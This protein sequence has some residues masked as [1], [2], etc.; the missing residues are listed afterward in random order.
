MNRQH[1]L[2][3]FAS[4]GFLLHIALL[5]VF[6][7]AKAAGIRGISW[8][9]PSCL[10][11]VV[12]LSCVLLRRRGIGWA[13]V[14]F[15]QGLFVAAVL[16]SGFIAGIFLDTSFD[17]RWYH[18]EG[19]IRLESGLDPLRETLAEDSL[20]GG[21]WS[22]R[23]VGA[24]IASAPV[25]INHYPKATEI[26]AA[27]VYASTG[28]IEVAKLF[29]ILL[30]LCV[31]ALLRAIFLL[32]APERR[33]TAAVAPIALVGNPIVVAQAWTNYTDGQLYLLLLGM[34]GFLI[35]HWRTED[36][37]WLL[38]AGVASICLANTKFT[39]LVFAVGVWAAYLAWSILRR[40]RG[41]FV[42]EAFAAS[43]VFLAVGSAVVGYSPYVRNLVGHG[44]PFH[45]V[46]GKDRIDIVGINEPARFAEEGRVFKL[47]QS[48][49]AAT[50]VDFHLSSGV[51]PP[52]VPFT[53]E[54]QEFLDGSSPDTRIGGF[55]PFFGGLVLVS[56][57][58]YLAGLA[59]RRP[60]TGGLRGAL[61]AVT[62]IDACIVVVV[63][64]SLA[65]PEAWWARYVPQ[66]WTLPFLCWLSIG[67]GIAIPGLAR[68][69]IA[70][71]SIVALAGSAGILVAT[72]VQTARGT[73]I[74]ERDF[75]RMKGADG[76][77]QVYLGQRTA[78][79]L[80]YQER[81]IPIR[82][83][84]TTA[85]MTGRFEE[86]LLYGGIVRHEDEALH[87]R[88]SSGGMDRGTAKAWF[89]DRVEGSLVALGRIGRPR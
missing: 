49:W 71:C 56:L 52:K 38:M 4:S 22:I 15:S 5:V 61:S 89:Q 35:L 79:R 14:G 78:D 3:S 45:P 50:S 44:H 43:A 42:L 20:P 85:Q 7:A 40:R 19:I 11:G 81:G 31:A 63:A 80:K 29:T 28:D 53:F 69:G 74:A 88:M 17:G 16:L 55:G 25:W 30:A 82:P 76:P 72:V 51:I 66:L 68:R 57:I 10:A 36:R 75:L 58:A 6:L 37:N 62:D 65:I 39:G 1:H 9:L 46:L 12:A 64:S 27:T 18:Q 21:L 73:L 33:F 86:T 83:V 2:L 26:V 67:P 13:K 23:Q 87:R 47:L 32:L 48:A 59:A 8:I 41:S 24:R 60:F 54:R 70:A 34:A 84:P 77:L